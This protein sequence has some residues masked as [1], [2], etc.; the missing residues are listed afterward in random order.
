MM[1]N[2]NEHISKQIDAY[3]KGN[4]TE[5]EVMELWADF[6]KN[7]SLLEELE[8]E[9]G[10]K[11]LVEEN[12]FE[13]ENISRAK[14][15]QL[16]RWTWHAAAAAVFVMV[17]LV[18]LFR[19]ETKTEMS[20]FIVQSIPADQVETAEGI[21]AKDM[22]LATADSIL[23]LGFSA[24]V[25]G[26]SKRALEYFNEVIEDYDT[27]P[28]GSKAFTNKGIILYNDSDYEASVVAFQSA[29][30]RVEDSRMIT[31]KAY[32][33]MGNALI[34]LGRLEEGR[35]AVGYAYSQNGVFRKPAFLLLHKLNIELGVVDYE[36]TEED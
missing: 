4:L 15:L 3:V 1:N 11:K 7:P 8:L 20:D 21:R 18:Q 2:T 19:I 17:A 23:N 22:V 28:Y 16:P 6:A 33:Y 12:V 27:E 14:N 36:Q 30:E 10:I 32:W 34:N 25:S 35:T 29:L 9:V 31:E 5:K 13:A 24:L 26:D